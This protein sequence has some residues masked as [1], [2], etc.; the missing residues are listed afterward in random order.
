MALLAILL[1]LFGFVLLGFGSG[2][3]GVSDQPI[4]HGSGS[5]HPVAKCSKRMGADSKGCKPANP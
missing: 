4:P 1:A 3:G 2:S 5:H